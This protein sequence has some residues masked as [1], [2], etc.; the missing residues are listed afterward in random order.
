M[1]LV[2]K[3]IRNLLS[4]P[5]GL[6]LDA[7]PIIIQQKNRMLE[8]AYLA[9]TLVMMIILLLIGK[10]AIDKTF[11]ERAIRTQKIMF[12]ALGLLA[13]QVY[14]FVLARAGVTQDFSFPPKFALF[15]I[16]P[17]FIF[18]GI[19]MAKNR[20]HAWIQNIPQHWLVYYQAFRVLI[21]T[22]FVYSVAAGILHP[23]VTIEGYNYDMV[24]AS[25]APIIGL[26][27]FQF[28]VLS[29]KIALLWNYLGLAVIAVII[30]L[31]LSTIYFPHIYGI[32]TNPFPTEFGSY[33]YVLVPG[34][35]M[36]SAV[37]MH[38]LSI[39]QLNGREKS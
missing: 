12:M 36:P 31:F 32:G 13:W 21:E 37:F 17:A 2:A 9:L 23:N 27:V 38:V 16:I 35:L 10:T 22:L 25:T 3:E 6:V 4:V 20:Q 30:F 26:L 33:P 11:T 15:L 34:F 14:I 5:A 39:V 28:N 8:L 18:T 1:G 19:F 24:F 29:K 7:V